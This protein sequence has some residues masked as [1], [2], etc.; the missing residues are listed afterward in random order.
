MTQNRL[1]GD[2]SIKLI[3]FNSIKFMNIITHLEDVRRTSISLNLQ[4]KL[5]FIF[6][7]RYIVLFASRLQYNIKNKCST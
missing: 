7:F 6:V 2:M 3:V 5:L 4:L 1:S